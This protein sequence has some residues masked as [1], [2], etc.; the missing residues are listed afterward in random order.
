MLQTETERD[1]N[2]SNNTADG[3]S[4]AGDDINSLQMKHKC[5]HIRIAN[6]LHTRPSL[7]SG[8][9]ACGFEDI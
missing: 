6:K 8:N 1:I 7:H 4:D 2:D 3:T 5:P 9:T